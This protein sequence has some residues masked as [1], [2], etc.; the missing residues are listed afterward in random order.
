[1]TEQMEICDACNGAGGDNQHSICSKCF[2]E[3]GIAALAKPSAT[4]DVAEL[5][6]R[7]RATEP[8]YDQ[9][10]GKH[11]YDVFPNRDGIEAA[12]ALASL[13]AQLAVKE[14]E[15]ARVMEVARKYQDTVEALFERDPETGDL[16]VEGSPSRSEE[17]A[18]RFIALNNVGKEMD[19]AL[20]LQAD[21][22][23]GDK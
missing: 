7:L 8:R 4:P 2:G 15:V 1:M 14:A 22:A 19:A 21:A 5:I 16:Y 11:L 17:V 9:L 13:Y 18:K 3:G 10:T 20:S 23:L 6:E 12:D